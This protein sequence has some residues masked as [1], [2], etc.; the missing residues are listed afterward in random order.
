[1]GF[2][3]ENWIGSQE[4]TQEQGFMFW[5]SSPGELMAS[6]GQV[7]QFNILVFGCF[8]YFRADLDIPK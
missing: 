3:C 7:A 1:M 4:E 6:S 8:G 5:C 2:W